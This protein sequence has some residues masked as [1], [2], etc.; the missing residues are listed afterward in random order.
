VTARS[1]KTLDLDLDPDR[2][3]A[4]GGT[5]GGDPVAHGWQIVDQP[6]FIGFGI[7]R[8]VTQIGAGTRCVMSELI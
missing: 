7:S 2:R 5:R 3:R 1:T 8:P 4:A 6:P